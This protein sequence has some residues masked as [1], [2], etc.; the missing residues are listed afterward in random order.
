MDYR[1]LFSSHVPTYSV[2]REREM[3]VS[4][5]QYQILNETAIKVINLCQT[6][7][8]LDSKPSFLADIFGGDMSDGDC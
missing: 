7:C 4:N 2:I 3:E 1:I 5:K 6:Q 8:R